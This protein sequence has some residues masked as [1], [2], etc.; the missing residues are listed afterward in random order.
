M[1]ANQKGSSL[2]K[3][4]ALEVSLQLIESLRPLVE[5]IRAEDASEASQIRRAASSV[6]H[7]LEEGRQR[8]GRD[9][10]NHYRYAAGSAAEIRGALR[11]A[12]AWGWIAPA[13]T[14]PAMAL[15][16]RLCAMLYRLAH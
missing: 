7:N 12:Q 16:D 14:A 5:K 9:R 10:V 1:T 6:P 11:V 13:D 4:D 8:K 2:M 15:L 3:F